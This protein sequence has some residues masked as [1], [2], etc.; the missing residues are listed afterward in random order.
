MK[1]ISKPIFPSKSKDSG[2]DRN[3]NTVI[4]KHAK[5]H[6]ED[7]VLQIV[8]RSRQDLEKSRLKAYKLLVP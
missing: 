5:M 6:G 7:V 1:T 2:N 3:G 4:T 8:I